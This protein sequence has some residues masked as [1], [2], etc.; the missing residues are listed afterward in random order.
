MA[1]QTRRIPSQQVIATSECLSEKP[2]FHMCKWYFSRHEIEDC[3]PSRQDGIDFE[4]ESQLRKFYCSFIKELGKKLKVPQVTIACALILCHQFYMRQSHAKNDWQTMATASMFLACKIEETPRLLRDVV[5]VAYEMINKWDSSAPQRIRRIEICDKQKEL[6]TSG[7]RLLLATI[8]FDLNIQL[9]YR[10]LVD[11]LKKLNI[12]PDLAKVAWNFVNDWLCTTLCLQY[13]P[14]YVAAG[15][16]FLAAKFQKVKLPTEKGKV[17]WLEFDISPK[18]LEEVTQ[19]MV[20]LLEQDKKRAVPLPQEKVLSGPSV[21]KMN[22]NSPQSTITSVSIASSHSS[23]GTVIESQVLS[24]R[25]CGLK[26]ALPCQTSDT[27]DA[28]NIVDDDGKSKP[29]TEKVDL[30]SSCKIA[31]IH[32]SYGKIDANR[33]REAL[34]RRRREGAANQMSNKIMNTELDSEAWIERELENGI[35]LESASSGKKQRTV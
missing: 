33:I 6:I 2:Q 17:W 24:E 19:E 21:G 1:E 9:P 4:K 20:R 26:Q 15:S 10:P 31:P 13:K 14:H 12:F 23:G 11:A 16:L 7:E 29:R 3:S 18:Q 35:E 28:S 30:V 8:A 27:G 34:R 32:D 22:T 5:V 25:N